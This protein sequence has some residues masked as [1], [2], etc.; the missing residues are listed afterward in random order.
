MTNTESFDE[1]LQELRQSVQ[2]L[3]TKSKGRALRR[4]REIQARL[5]LLA[6]STSFSDEQSR[7]AMLYQTSRTLGSSLDLTEALNQVMD[8]VIELTGAGRGCVMLL[9]RDTGEL[10]LRAARNFECRDLDHEEMQLSR[11]VINEVLHSAEGIVTSNAQTDTR[12]SDQDSVLRYALRSILCVPLRVRDETIGVIYVDNSAKSSLFSESDCDM[13]DALAIQAAVAIENARLYTQTDAALA[14]RVAE[15]ETLQ[16]ID[17]ELNTGLDFDRVLE[18]TLEWAVRETGANQGWI[19]IR[20]GETP[21]MAVVTGVGKGSSFNLDEHGEIGPETPTMSDAHEYFRGRTL[22]QITMP[23]RRED[24]II[25]VIG[26]Q[27]ENTPFPPSARPNLHRLAE[28]AAVAIENT[29]LY[30]SVQAANLAKSQF[31]SVVS[32]ELRMPMTA[33]CGY[34]DLL[35]QGAAG[36][37]TE[38]QVQYLYT[39]SSNVDRMEILVADLSDISRIET[40]RLMINVNVV[41]IEDYVRE[42]VAGLLPQ[43]E[44][45]N[46]TVTLDVPDDLPKVVADPSRLV[47]ILTNLL[48]NAH[49]YTPDGGE[50]VVNALHMQDQVRVSVNDNGIGI[51]AA[52]QAD[53][54][55]QFFRSDDPTVRDQQGWGLGLHVAQRLIHLMGG[56]IG[57]ESDFGKGSTFW[58]SL[59]IAEPEENTVS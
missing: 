27:R 8:A 24:V 58:F 7:L 15:L 52:D 10:D 2:D 3:I 20:S 41:P 14:Q 35:R 40:G 13:L 25:A 57:F 18:L 28:H 33:I 12:F 21:V 55:S 29:R 1:Q 17:R 59:P 45:K 50:V 39:I 54:F 53:L 5:E 4:A 26:V 9:N 44:E 37:I 48:S 31:I 23:V 11:T 49:K 42:T 16:Q 34:A 36:P 38:K 32:H 22:N 56:E 30:R 6:I 47:Q 46:Q 43:F 19:A 51:S